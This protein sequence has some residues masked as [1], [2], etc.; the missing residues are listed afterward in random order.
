MPRSPLLAAA[1]A[2]L[3]LLAGAGPALGAHAA[4]YQGCKSAHSSDFAGSEC[5]PGKYHSGPGRGHPRAL[6]HGEER[7]LP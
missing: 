4:N 6:L 7:P 3:L 1:T 5:G 2:S